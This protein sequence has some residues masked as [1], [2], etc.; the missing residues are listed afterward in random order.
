MKLPDRFSLAPQIFRTFIKNAGY[1]QRFGKFQAGIQR[2]C[3]AVTFIA[4]CIAKVV[5]LYAHRHSL[6][7]SKFLL[8][9]PTFFIQDAIVIL[10]ARLLTRNY[11]QK[12]VQVAT[13]LAAVAMRYDWCPIYPQNGI[14]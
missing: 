11:R 4:L 13:T 2:Y 1:A 8:W 6:L 7:P 9:G 14:N 10:F 3:F 5:H 12:W